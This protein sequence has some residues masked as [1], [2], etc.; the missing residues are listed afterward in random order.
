MEALHQLC[1][2][3]I[4]SLIENKYQNKS[5]LLPFSGKEIV[6]NF[7][8]FSA[9]WIITD[10]GHLCSESKSYANNTDLA[11][12]MPL[13]AAFAYT[14]FERQDAL[15]L[16]KVVGDAEL[17][18]TLDKLFDQIQRNNE[19]I[20]AFFFGD[21]AAYR[22]NKATKNL[23]KTFVNLGKDIIHNQINFFFENESILFPRILRR[24]L[25]NELR[26]EVVELNNQ[27]AHLEKYIQNTKTLPDSLIDY[28]ANF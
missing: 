2:Y 22:I 27:I 1:L 10:K 24:Q 25:F 11:I 9:K 18:V 8:F 5:P 19:E 4:N 20:L 28:Y 21:I 23:K 14:F 6:L 17:A 26:L 15:G 3:L 13:A 12:Y 7:G 16:I